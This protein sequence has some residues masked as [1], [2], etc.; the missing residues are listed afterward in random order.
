MKSLVQYLKNQF[1]CW[2]SYWYYD[3]HDASDDIKQ[4]PDHFGQ[5]TC[6]R[7]GKIYKL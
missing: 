1:I 3:I 5:Y 7:C 2:W 4:V 6:Q